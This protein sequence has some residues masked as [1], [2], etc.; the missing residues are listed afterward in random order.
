VLQPEKKRSFS[1]GRDVQKVLPT[2]MGIFTSID[3]YIYI[4][5]KSNREKMVL[6]HD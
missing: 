1:V 4:N 6:K 5:P 2:P 3:I